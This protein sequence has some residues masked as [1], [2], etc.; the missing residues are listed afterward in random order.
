MMLI[1]IPL[2]YFLHA[3]SAH[4]LARFGLVAIMILSAV[5]VLGTYSRGGLIGLLFLSLY[6]WLKSTRKILVTVCAIAVGV[7]AWSALPDRWFARMSSIQHVDADDSFQGRQDAWRFAFNAASSR[8]TGVGFSGTEDPTVFQRYLPEPT[9]TFNRGRAAHSIYFQVLGDHGFIGL[10][11][12]LAILGLAWRLTGRLSGRR[13]GSDHQLHA[14][15][16]MVRVSLA[17]YCVAGA[18][19]NVAYES[20]VFCLLGLLSAATRLI[21]ARTP[22]RHHPSQAARPA[23]STAL[24]PTSIKVEEI[25][26]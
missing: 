8:L 23:R 12:Y 21:P 16:Q 24:Q 9:A 6:F 11:L 3:T 2:A 1:T 18:A 4:R 10:A 14:L 22:A 5:A 20:L 13:S 25:V 15:G 19:L 26:S 7:V 17:T